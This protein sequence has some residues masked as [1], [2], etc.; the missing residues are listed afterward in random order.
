MVCFVYFFVLLRR[1]VPQ[2]SCCV[3]GA[4]VFQVLLFVFV[5]VILELVEFLVLFLVACFVYLVGVVL[6]YLRV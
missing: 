4:V 1:V 6:V 5:V 2:L 3:F